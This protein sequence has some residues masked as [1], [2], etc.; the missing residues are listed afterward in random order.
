MDNLITLT[1]FCTEMD[2]D[3]TLASKNGAKFDYKITNGKL[4]VSTYDNQ[5]ID[6][7]RCG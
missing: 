2:N 4:Y 5:S 6:M 7:R 3:D 1:T